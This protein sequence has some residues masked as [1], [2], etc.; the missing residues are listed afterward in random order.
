MTTSSLIA[1]GAIA[2]GAVGLPFAAAHHPGLK[3][4]MNPDAF[5]KHG[6]FGTVASINGSI[7]T[8]TDKDGKTITIDASNADFMK[9]PGNAAGITISDIQV[10][11]K[12]M[13]MGDV[14][15]TTVSAK[16]ID[17][18]SLMGRILFGGKVTAVNGSSITIEMPQRPATPP[19]QGQ[20][21]EAPTMTTYTVDLTSASLSKPGKEATTIALSDIKAGDRV[22]ITGTLN[23]TTVSAK[24]LS[25]MGQRGERA[26]GEGR[27]MRGMPFKGGFGH[28]MRGQQ[29]GAQQQESN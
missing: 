9:G 29:Q 21:P 11:D 4:G 20:K 14:N 8:V 23:G 2:L 13:A 15:D 18:A 19:T 26:F 27:G 10:G 7:I 22:A 25:D 6:A 5:A 1:K 12:L 24:T 28:G 3:A 17:D 16:H